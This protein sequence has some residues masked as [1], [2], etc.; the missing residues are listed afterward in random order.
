ML[1]TNQAATILQVSRR[2]VEALITAG[3]LPAQ[4]FGRDWLIRETDLELVKVRYPG[5]PRAVPPVNSA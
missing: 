3:R 2:R 4:K 1:T 5:R